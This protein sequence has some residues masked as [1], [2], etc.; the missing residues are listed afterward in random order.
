MLNSVYSGD[1]IVRTERVG[2]LDYCTQISP[3]VKRFKGC[4]R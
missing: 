1:N 3:Q 4:L 2:G